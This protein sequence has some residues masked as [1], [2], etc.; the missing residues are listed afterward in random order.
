MGSIVDQLLNKPTAATGRYAT[1]LQDLGQQ[2]YATNQGLSG[3]PSAYEDTPYEPPSAL[4][5]EW[6]LFLQNNVPADDPAQGKTFFE[7][8]F[9]RTSGKPDPYNSWEPSNDWS[10]GIRAAYGG[11]N[12][13]GSP[14][15]RLDQALTILGMPMGGGGAG[16]VMAAKAPAGGVI[17]SLRGLSAADG[18]K[19]A[20]K[21]SHLKKSGA[22]AEGKYVG[23]PRNIQTKQQLNKMRREFDEFVARDTRGADW[24]DRYR[25]DVDKVTGGDPISNAWMAA[26]EGQWSAGVSP[27]AELGFAIKENNG[28]LTGFPV[29]A[30]RPLMHQAHNEAARTGDI[31]KYIRGEK[32]GE[33]ADHVV[34]GSALD[35]TATGVNDFRHAI[36]LGYTEASGIPQRQGLSGTQHTFADY[37]TALAVGR[38]NKANLGG[39]SDWTGEKLQAAPWVLQKAD[40]LYG[41]GVAYKK[42]AK[43]QLRFEK[44]NDLSDEKVEAMARE[45]AFQDANRQIGDFYPKHTAHATYESMVG[46][47]TG[48]LPGLAGATDAEKAAIHADPRSTFATAPGGRDSIYSG[49]R[50]GD[51]GVAAR[52]Q[53][54]VE[55]QGIYQPPGG[56]LEMNP[57]EVARP[58][59]GFEV[60]QSGQKLLPAGDRAMLEAG[61]TFRA[62]LSG[63]DAGAAHVTT[64]GGKA[65]DQRS[66]RIPMKGKL[67]KQELIDVKAV[68][69]KYNL[70]DAV[71]TGTGVT[72]TRFYTDK[73]PV[74]EE[75]PGD[76]L[77]KLLDEVR[78]V[79]PSAEMGSRVHV[80]SVYAGLTD[81]WKAG[82]GS[83]EVSQA[84]I[85][86]INVTPEMRAAFD[87]NP[88]IALNAMNL[89]SRDNDLA[90]TFGTTVRADLQKLRAIVASGPGW[91]GRV[92][93]A[94]KK[95]LVP[96]IA[97][98][99]LTSA[100]GE[101]QN[102]S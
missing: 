33:Y 48:H 50:Y 72:G 98:A 81:A 55:S 49:L 91:V 89:I 87:N 58:L 40:D 39:R 96:G 32:T 2:P 75:L 8:M 31:T 17:P 45:A 73:N 35:D 4:D 57:G 63:Q 60:Q 27:Q 64:T 29:K 41:N 53:P 52:V 80:D 69:A 47:N 92:E 102:G 46:P 38:A 61:E 14:V 13:D 97:A 94:I 30:G 70:D 12:P 62:G 67:S 24:Y 83:G 1:A 42:R 71:D 86:K 93:T 54:T 68:L 77:K 18:V 9:G 11:Y 101:G 99:F 5:M 19:Q 20:R 36:N 95:G 26:Q 16:G 7:N 44:A 82:E 85:D 10:D 23:G 66:V 28:T 51:T 79:L 43:A 37:E 3:L 56:T 22:S 84:I 6:M 34:P 90:K 15:N 65:G 88:D 25:G 21:E 78:G 100:Y 76:Q 59:V 74:P